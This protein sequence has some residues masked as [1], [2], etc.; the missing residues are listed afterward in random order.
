MLYCRYYCKAWA[1]G[2]IHIAIEIPPDELD[3]DPHDVI[4]IK[5]PPDSLCITVYSE[6]EASDYSDSIEITT[7][8]V[9]RKIPPD[10][11]YRMET[12]APRRETAFV[13]IE[14]KITP[15]NSDSDEG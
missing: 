7:G 5:V 3:N 12:H 6:M 14:I 9:E 13:D 15:E 8:N 10:D 2:C 1:Q 4:D 11:M